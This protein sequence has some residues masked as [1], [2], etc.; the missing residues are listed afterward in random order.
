MQKYMHSYNFRS[1]ISL[2]SLK[3]EASKISFIPP[4]NMT[5]REIECQSPLTWI[6]NKIKTA[7]LGF[8]AILT[9][10]ANKL[11]LNSLSGA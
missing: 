7:K 8:I 10:I 6:V 2:N 1:L 4:L 5:H 3:P 9:H 11:N